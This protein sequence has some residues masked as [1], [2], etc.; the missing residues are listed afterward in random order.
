MI[1]SK[2]TPKSNFEIAHTHTLVATG[3]I[4]FD[5]SLMMFKK[6]CLMQYNLQVLH[7]QCVSI[8]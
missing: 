8:N 1:N 2:P 3:Y 5:H 7:K 4:K 6:H